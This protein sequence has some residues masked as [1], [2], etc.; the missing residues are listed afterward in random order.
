LSE[1]RGIEER[2]ILEWILWKDGG[3]VGIG[4]EQGPVMGSWEHSNEPFSS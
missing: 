1:D 2:I 3:K 4:S